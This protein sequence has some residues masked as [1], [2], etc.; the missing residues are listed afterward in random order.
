[1]GAVTALGKFGRTTLNMLPI[2]FHLA[3]KDAPRILCLGAH[4]DDIEIGALAT[5]LSLAERHPGAHID[6]VVFGASENRQEEAAASAAYCTRVYHDAKVRIHEFQ[7]GHFPMQAA[8]IKTEFEAL[9][10]RCEPDL[11]FTHY[12]H[13][14]HQ[15]HAVISDLT[16]QTFRN[17][18][19]FEYEIPKYDG[20]LGIPN[21]FNAVAETL[22]EQKLEI[23][24]RFFA[25]QQKKNW[26]VPETFSALMRLRGIECHSDSGFAEAF[27]CRKMLLR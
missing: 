13:D 10:L 26:F 24:D 15:D 22:V 3:N 12:R 20:D 23:L 18:L 11:I 7:D 9:K 4:S 21:V 1:M 6:W 8:A 5:I 17:H 19:I 2:D 14:R 16:W 27:H 25:T